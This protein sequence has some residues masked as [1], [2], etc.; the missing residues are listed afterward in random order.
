[1]KLIFAAAAAAALIASLPPMP[2]SV[3]SAGLKPVQECAI[4]AGKPNLTD[5]QIGHAMAACNTALN[6][7]LSQIA[8]RRHAGQS[9]PAEGCGP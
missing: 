2:N 1:M 6:S 8:T 4:A 9:R 3:M 7:D 5:R